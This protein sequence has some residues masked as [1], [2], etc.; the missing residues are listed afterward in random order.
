[1]SGDAIDAR[2]RRCS[3]WGW[4][5]DRNGKIAFNIGK[6]K[7]H[8]FTDIAGAGFARLTRKAA[9]HLIDVPVNT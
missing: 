3:S 8:H 4:R 9:T 5:R 6:R 2:V 1:M 7:R